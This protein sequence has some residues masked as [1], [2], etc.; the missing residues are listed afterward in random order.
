MIHDMIKTIPCLQEQQQQQQ[1]QEEE[2]YSN[3]LAAPSF[4]FVDNV[5]RMIRNT[6]PPPFDHAIN[7]FN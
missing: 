3:N 1:Q 7:D 6:A 2:E 5:P 4:Y